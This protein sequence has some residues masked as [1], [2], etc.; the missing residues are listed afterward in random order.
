MVVET[1]VWV[2]FTREKVSDLVFVCR[3]SEHVMAKASTLPCS[4]YKARRVLALYYIDICMYLW[5]TFV[6]ERIVS[7]PLLRHYSRCLL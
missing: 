3:N 6:M 2:L 1:C 4:S 7:S 5:L